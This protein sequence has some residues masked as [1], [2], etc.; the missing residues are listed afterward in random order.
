MDRIT[1]QGFLYLGR[2][3]WMRIKPTQYGY[4][5]LGINWINDIYLE[6]ELPQPVRQAILHG[7]MGIRPVLEVA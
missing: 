6:H 2:Q 5:E 4:G 1:I 3:K 7:S